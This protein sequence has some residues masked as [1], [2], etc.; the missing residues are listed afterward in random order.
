MVAINQRGRQPFSLT[1]C[2]HIY[3][4]NCIQPAER[5][6]PQCQQADIFSVELQ[7]PS[8][9]RVQNFFVPVK[10]LLESLNTIYGFQHNQMKIVIQRFL[11]MD[12]KY[13]SLKAHYY[14]L[15]RST[16]FYKDKCE[17]LKME[18]A[19]LSK[20]LMSFEMRDRTTDNLSE[21]TASVNSSNRK[22]MTRST[23]GTSTG[24]TN[25][26]SVHS[27]FNN[28]HIPNFSTV[29]SRKSC[30]KIDANFT[31]TAKR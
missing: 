15:S 28:L 4:Q 23:A 10:E 18:K 24:R 26:S 19:E 17:K 11:E 7:Q 31:F 16:K 13:E 21:T 3:C 5:H 30:G 29:K 20:K 9:S 12:K 25:L 14:N 8:L 27:M 1:Q 2:G 6:C 22:F